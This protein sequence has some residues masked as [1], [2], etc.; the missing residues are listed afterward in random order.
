MEAASPA[1][2]FSLL[3][4][5]SH[6]LLRHPRPG[7]GSVAGMAITLFC[8]E[9][10]AVGMGSRVKGRL[11]GPVDPNGGGRGKEELGTQRSQLIHLP[12][13]LE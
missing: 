2:C 6:S 9:T 5:P 12:W 3:F 7:D 11:G 10:E 13:A 1:L 8:W 4:L